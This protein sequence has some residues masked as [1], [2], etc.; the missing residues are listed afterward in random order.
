M[1]FRGTMTDRTLSTLLT[2]HLVGCDSVPST[3]NS[4]RD[5]TADGA[6]AA[7]AE[8]DPG[9]VPST[10]VGW[11]TTAWNSTLSSGYFRDYTHMAHIHT[12]R[13]T[14]IHR[15]KGLTHNAGEYVIQYLPP[16]S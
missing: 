1:Q 12:S 4:C 2:C 3:L 14:Y 5:G 13:C 8:E 7:L 9:S 10:H 16:D 11:I 15:N 6:L